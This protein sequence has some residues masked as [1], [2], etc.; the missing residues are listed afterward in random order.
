[1]GLYIK[2]PQPNMLARQAFTFYKLSKNWSNGSL[3]PREMGLLFIEEHWDHY[4]IIRIWGTKRNKEIITITC[5]STEA[6]KTKSVYKEWFCYIKLTPCLR[7]FCSGCNTPSASKVKELLSNKKEKV[8]RFFAFMYMQEGH[9]HCPVNQEIL[10][11]LL[12][13]D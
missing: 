4:S 10:S 12:T 13:K 1:M 3:I 9:L 5:S 8:S 2:R 7:S 6:L 11:A